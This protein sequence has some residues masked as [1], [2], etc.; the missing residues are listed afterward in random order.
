MADFVGGPDIK[1]DGVVFS[2]EEEDCQPESPRSPLCVS[3]ELARGRRQPFFPFLDSDDSEDSDQLQS[4]GNEL[5]KLKARLSKL[6]VGKE[7][8]QEDDEASTASAPDLDDVD[9]RFRQLQSSKTMPLTDI[10]KIV[11]LGE[12]APPPIVENAPSRPAP[13]IPWPIN[14]V[15]SPIRTKIDPSSPRAS[16]SPSPAELP[17]EPTTPRAWER[18]E[19]SQVF[20]PPAHSHLP[21][22]D[23]FE[24]LLRAAPPPGKSPLR[25][26]S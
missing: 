9:F 18:S 22:E 26:S 17:P 21:G 7:Q 20:T 14:K 1:M 2:K 12:R 4:R 15:L 23:E 8:G 10:E 16:R 24:A 3:Q 6:S 19:A 13:P 25:V 11:V 5:Q